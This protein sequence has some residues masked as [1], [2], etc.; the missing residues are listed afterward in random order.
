M[1]PGIRVFVVDDTDHVRRM[2]TRMLEMDGFEV[3][4]H[5][6]EGSSAVLA[7]V[8]GEPDVVVIDYKMPDMDGL[9]TARL[10]RERRPDQ[11]VILY[12]AFVDEEIERAAAAIGVAVCVGKIEG[13]GSLEQ[14]IRRLVP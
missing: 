4:G 2:L 3:V 12:T 11:Q 7:V 14:E 9:E 1:A 13:L 10:I 8:D 5:A 6:A